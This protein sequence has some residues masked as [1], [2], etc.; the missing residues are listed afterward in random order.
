MKRWMV[1]TV[2]LAATPAFGQTMYK[3]PGES[4]EVKFQQMPCSPQGGGEVISVKPIKPIGIES[5]GLRPG[6]Q[7]MLKSFQHR[8]DADTG[9]VRIGMTEEEARRAWGSPSYINHSSYQDQW[10]YH[11]GH[12]KAQYL[13][14]QN[15]KLVAFN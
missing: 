1:W 9:T 2:I 6:E 10:V 13:Y 15:G 8:I 11:R 3:C 5:P 12:A 7:E 4:G 14:F